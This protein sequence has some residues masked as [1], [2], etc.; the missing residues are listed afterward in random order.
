ML[1]K[2]LK[3]DLRTTGQHVIPAYLIFIAISIINK[4]CLEISYLT[5][6]ESTSLRLT[7]GLTF[8]LYGLTIFV[9]NIITTVFVVM[10]FYKTM[11]GEQGYLTHTL[12]AQTEVLIISKI[13]CSLIW[14]LVVTILISSS[15][16]FMVFGHIEELSTFLRGTFGFMWQ[17][18]L[19]SFDFDINIYSILLATASVV[20]AVMSPVTF[21]A[22]IALGNLS[23]K[24]KV[25]SAVLSYVGLYIVLKIFRLI[26]NIIF[27][28]TKSGMDSSAAAG[29][30]NGKMIFDIM[31][32]IAITA[33]LYVLTVHIFKKRL[34]LE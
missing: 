5:G 31:V 7:Q 30:V 22:C 17:N 3:Y 15:I 10:Y 26:I 16:F 20:N 33:V 34:N 25:M 23:N 32:N 13:I 1:G 12:P 19:N 9:I 8:M 24:H 6:F 4:I 14:Q 2:V 28:I 11:A 29:M 18:L 21:L 27:E